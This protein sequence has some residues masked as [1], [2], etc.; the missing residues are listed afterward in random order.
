MPRRMITSE[1]FSNDKV[2]ELDI[3]GRLLF[4]GIITNADDDGRLKA[5]PKFL[6]AKIFP[7]DNI[8]PETIK[9]HR[10]LC[11]TLNLIHIYNIN[12]SEYICLPGWLEHQSIRKDLY[13]ASTLPPPDETTATPPSRSRD[14]TV[15]PPS[16]SR[17]ETVTQSKISK[18]KIS[19]SKKDD[20][21]TLSSPLREKTREVFARLDKMRGYRLDI[22]R[23]AEAAA[24]IRMLKKDYTPDQIIKTW[25]ELK[26]DNFWQGKELLLISVEK[27][28]GAMLKDG[29]YRQGAGKVRTHPDQYTD[30]EELLIPRDSD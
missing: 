13:K 4:I 14:K 20:K 18:S 5:S 15:T 6:K 19:K 26:S 7:Y 11:N 12:G 27:Q 16:L 22:K 17:D 10:D 9:E 25:A 21:R 24:I 28:I 3:V 30:P 29:T 1:I 23:K 2:G 8:D